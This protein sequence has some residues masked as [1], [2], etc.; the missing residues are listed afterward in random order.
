MHVYYLVLLVTVSVII[1]K[2]AQFYCDLLEGLYSPTSSFELQFL[3]DMDLTSR[4]CQMGPGQHNIQ[5]YLFSLSFQAG[6]LVY[7]KMWIFFR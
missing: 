3:F 1:L 2:C 4:W 6:P 7:E 5:F